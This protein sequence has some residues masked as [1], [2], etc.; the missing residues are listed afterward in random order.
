MEEIRCLRAL[1]VIYKLMKNHKEAANV[2]KKAL[3]L[4]IFH[5]GTKDEEVRIVMEEL[6]FSLVE[7]A[8]FEEGIKQLQKCIEMRQ[9][10]M[11]LSA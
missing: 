7:G 10:A 1:G 2:Y 5:K 4:L 8:Y 3:N 6:G 11:F 9:E